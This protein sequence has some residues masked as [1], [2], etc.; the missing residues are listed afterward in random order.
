MHSTCVQRMTI[1]SD[2]AGSSIVA[3]RDDLFV[4]LVILAVI[5]IE[6]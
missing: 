6:W 3:R 4:I 2:P 1:I 5:F